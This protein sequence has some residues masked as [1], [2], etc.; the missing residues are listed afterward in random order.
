[1]TATA[2]AFQYR[3]LAKDEPSGARL[4][5]VHQTA[6]QLDV[7]VIGKEDRVWLTCEDPDGFWLDGRDGR[8]EPLFITPS[9]FAPAGAGVAALLRPD[10]P[11]GGL[12]SQSGPHHFVPAI[13]DISE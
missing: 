1:M 12:C 10:G 5:A 9:G 2:G 6:N 11:F 8:P 7:L 4:V 13:A 3:S